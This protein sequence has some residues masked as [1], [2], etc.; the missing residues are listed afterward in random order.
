MLEAC[1]NLTVPVFAAAC[2]LCRS[3]QGFQSS[4][5]SYLS[6]CPCWYPAA[7]ARFCLKVD[8]CSCEVQLSREAEAPRWSLLSRKART[9]QGCCLG[10]DPHAALRKR[11]DEEPEPPWEPPWEPQSPGCFFNSR[12]FRQERGTPVRRATIV[13][14]AKADGA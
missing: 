14:M 11:G 7:K 2:P 3:V 13:P 8:S 10:E 6:I 5:Q 9:P 12:Q 4:G 1:E